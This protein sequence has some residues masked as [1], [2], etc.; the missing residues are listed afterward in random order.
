MVEDV[1]VEIEGGVVVAEGKRK[2]EGE[3]VN[4]VSVSIV[5]LQ[6]NVAFDLA[7][8]LITAFLL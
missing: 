1:V 7:A 4:L 2:I 8:C 5:L 3:G 6:R